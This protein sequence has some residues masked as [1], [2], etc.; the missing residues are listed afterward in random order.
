MFER[1][2]LV[3]LAGSSGCGGHA[4]SGGLEGPPETDA[5]GEEDT[6]NAG[7]LDAA[8]SADAIVTGRD[9]ASPGD[10][11]SCAWSSPQASATPCNWSVNLQGD[12]AACAGFASSGT[13]AQC[14]AACGT[15]PDS[16][17][18]ATTCSVVAN[19]VGAWPYSVSCW[20]C[21]QVPILNGGRRPDYFAKLGFG[22]APRGREVGTH[23][24]R[25]ACMEAGS[26]DAFRRLRDELRAHRAPRRLV[27][28]AGRAMRDEIRHVRQT[29]ALSRR[30]RERP[31]R[32]IS[33]QAHGARSL[34]AIALENGVEGCVRETYSALECLWQAHRATDSVVRT[35][36][37]RIA[38]DELRHLELSWEVRAWAMARLARAARERVVAAERR[39][40]ALLKAEMHADPGPALERDAGLPPAAV[41]R[42]LVDAIA[43]KL[44]AA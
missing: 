21:T 11:A 44:E 34:E 22:P 43:S 20:S 40:I 18:A 28:A 30:F 25:A 6:G 9:A 27:R 7:S 14:T 2:V 5:A 36:M 31:V 41:S 32:P 8:G 24:A 37:R 12:P 26:V 39:E 13:L 33:A 1:V 38:R 35:T 3:L 42:A 23:F 16:D 15:N 29:A 17:A 4:E 10:G 19:N